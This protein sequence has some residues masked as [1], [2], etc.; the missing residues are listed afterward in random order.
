M[1]YLQLLDEQQV[2]PVQPWPPHCPYRAEQV[3]EVGGDEEAEVV[4]VL[5]EL[6]EL[7]LDTE[8]EASETVMLAEPELLK[9]SV[10]TI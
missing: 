10:E 2:G 4:D 3:P 7:E 1:E 9:P 8:P 5:D 6:E